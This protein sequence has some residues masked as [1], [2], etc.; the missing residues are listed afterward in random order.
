MANSLDNLSS[1]Y[2]PNTLDGINIISDEVSTNALLVDGSNFMLADLNMNFHNIKNLDAGIDGA[3]AVNKSQLDSKADTTYVNTQDNLRVLKTGDTMT[4]NL[5]MGSN[6]ITSDVNPLQSI[7]LARKAYVD[8]KVPISG[9]VDITGNIG[10]SNLYRIINLNDGFFSNDA[11]TVGQVHLVSNNVSSASYIYSNSVSSSSFIFATTQSSLKVSKSG[12]TMTGNL[13]MGSY[14]VTTTANPTTFDT[15]TRKGYV[16]TE[17]NN[18]AAIKVSKSGDTMTGNLNMGSNS[19][20]TTANPT[21]FDTLT[22][23]GYVDTEV[24]NFAVIKVSKSGDT[25]TGNLNMGSNSVTTTTNP[26]T[27]D[28]LTR[29]GY[30]DTEINNSASTKV[31][32]SGDTM[33]GKLT[34]NETTGTLAS[35]SSGTIVL[36]HQNSGGGNS[37]VFKSKVDT[38]DYGYIQYVDTISGSQKSQLTFGVENNSD[39]TNEDTISFKLN[40][41]ERVRISGVGNVGIGTTS[42]SEKLDVVGNFKLSGTIIRSS[43]TSGEIIKNKI[44]NQN[45]SG[46]GV[47]II[48]ITGTLGFA[49]IENWKTLSFTMGNGTLTNSDI[50]ITIDAPYYIQGSTGDSFFIRVYDATSTT[51]QTITFKP[52]NFIDANGGGTR[53]CAMLPIIATY[54]P[55]QL[56]TTATRTIKIDFWNYSLNDDIKVCYISD[57]LT[58]DT[59]S[60][61]ITEYRK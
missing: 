58:Q 20:T 11:A 59:Y 31:S 30:V 12:D 21:T 49:N 37:I 3:D 9:G 60:I 56:T 48:N 16:D 5:V 29:K 8:T 22:R 27:V 33:T 19:V 32:K 40:G 41:S 28:M 51:E 47:Q 53:S 46:T 18:F 39:T 1:Y 44:Y 13:N 23:K 50:E 54:T 26:T 35:S 25:M 42:P 14:S 4:G 61:R 7:H 57:A 15:L 10:F 55:T 52:Q 38:T 34:I 45:N 36:E 17:V 6:Y 2:L 24:N 43:W